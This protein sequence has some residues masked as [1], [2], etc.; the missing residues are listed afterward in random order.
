MKLTLQGL[1]HREDW[2]SA[3]YHL[4]AFDYPS[5]QARTKKDPCWIH[6]GCGNI[7]RAFQARIVQELLEQGEMDRGLIAVSGTNP[8]AIRESFA[9]YDNL[10]ILV[11][12]GKEGVLAKTVVGSIMEALPALGQ[13]AGEAARLRE[14]FSSPS[15][16]MASFTITE[17]GYSLL[18]TSGQYRP[19]VAHDL[20]TGPE[21]C[22]SY[23][24]QV[25]ALLYHRFQNGRHPLAMISMDNCSHNGDVLKHSILTFAETWTKKQLVSNGF[26]GWLSDPSCVSFPWTMIDKITPRPD[27][28]IRRILEDDGVEDLSIRSHVTGSVAAPFVNAES[29]EYLVVEDSFPGGRPPLQ[30]AGIL[31]TSR[32][33]V[34][35]AERMKVCTCL[36]PLH[37]ALAIF[38]CL[39]GYDRM[40]EEMKNPAL[41]RLALSVGYQ[42]GMPA[43]TDPGILDPDQFLREVVTLRIPNPYLPDTPQR[44]ATDTS[45]K[46]P[47]RFG[48]TLK[49]WLSRSD[50]SVENLVWIPLVFAGWLRYLMAVDDQ[51]NPFTP[52]PDPLLAKLA[53]LMREFHL[54]IQPDTGEIYQKLEP[55]FSD[56][57]LWGVDLNAC[58]L[59]R[60]TVKAFQR[61]LAGTGAV[62]QL[63]EQMRTLPA[64]GI[65]ADLKNLWM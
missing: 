47:V 16:Q 7:F 59:S 60:K 1:S 61:M 24:G 2:L 19:E 10:S 52:S 5:V 53:G 56:A 54:G 31:L 38:G 26:A 57:T 11:T 32:K 35:D 17:K 46:L 64:C 44:I 40:S 23:L 41:A 48:E 14:I 58:G 30:K 63:L 49:V 45:Q 9:P 3:G 20:Q 15:L 65:P 34:E 37:T 29:C 43:V 13:T 4:P 62:R 55:L 36:N 28:A 6:F 39:L 50:L 8:S 25:T 18:G 51:G 22:Q 42:E 33:T 21:N 12:L 27:A